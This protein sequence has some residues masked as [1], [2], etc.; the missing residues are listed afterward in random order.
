MEG[1]LLISYVEIVE[2]FFNIFAFM[3]FRY[4]KI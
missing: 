4:A 1:R 2:L 3:L